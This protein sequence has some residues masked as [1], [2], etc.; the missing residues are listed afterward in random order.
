MPPQ[1][2]ERIL[3]E[4]LADSE[5]PSGLLRG[6][7]ASVLT[8]AIERASLA[9]NRYHD[10]VQKASQQREEQRGTKRRLADLD[11]EATEKIAKKA[12]LEKAQAAI[13]SLSQ[14]ESFMMSL[15]DRWQK[16]SDGLATL[17][18][19]RE[20]EHQALRQSRTLVLHLEECGLDFDLD[21]IDQLARSVMSDTDV[22]F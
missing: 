3:E 14:C 7:S 16:E 9:L 18:V 4:P 17:D 10:T 15:I 19:R 2:E 11:R 22:T 8:A 13:A 6:R 20:A 1:V 12:K 21:A 5:A